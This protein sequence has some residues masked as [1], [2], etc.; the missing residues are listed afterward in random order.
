LARFDV[1]TLRELAGSKT[2]ARGKEYFEDGEV[3]ILAIEPGRV[4]AQVTGSEDYRTELRGRGMTIDG[5][6]S[7]RA[8]VDWGFCKHMVAVGM[9]AN[10]ASDAEGE[11]GGALSRIRQHLMT[12]SVDALAEMI[13]NKRNRIQSC[14]AS[15]SWPPPRSMG[16]MLQSK[17]G[18]ER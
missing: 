8:H 4:L 12:K 13:Y 10:A 1:D 2:F 16:T 7:C 15:W 17:H 5:H 3:E 6:C 9:A 14:S 11:G 18:C